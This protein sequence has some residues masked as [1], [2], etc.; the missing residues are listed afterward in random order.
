M[1]PGELQLRAYISKIADEQWPD[2]VQNVG[3][4]VY[5]GIPH[6]LTSK[7]KAAH[8]LPLLSNRWGHWTCD[9]GAFELK[10]FYCLLSIP[11]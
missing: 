3:Q 8:K 4:S 1:D 7:V 2:W 11:L 9:H 10:E 5:D 6:P